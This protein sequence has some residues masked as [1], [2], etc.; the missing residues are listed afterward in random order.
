M[1]DSSPPSP[2]ASLARRGMPLSAGDPWPEAGVHLRVRRGTFRIPAGLD[3]LERKRAIGQRIHPD[4]N[5]VSVRREG[6]DEVITWRI[7]KVHP[8]E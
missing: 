4:A 5:N 3:E 2:F 1:S 8:N 6:A 7:I